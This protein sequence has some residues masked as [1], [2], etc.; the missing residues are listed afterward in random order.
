LSRAFFDDARRHDLPEAIA[1]LA[2]PL[3]V[4][5]GDHDEIIPLSEAEQGQA[6]N[7]RRVT[8]AVIPGADHMFSR[9]TDRSAIVAKVSAWF[10]KQLDG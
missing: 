3:L 10:Q 1:G 7:P 6:L 2:C 9:K 4:V 5:H 8:L